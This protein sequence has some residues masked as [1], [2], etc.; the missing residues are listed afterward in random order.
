MQ[1]AYQLISTVNCLIYMEKNTDPPCGRI[2]KVG[3]YK[4]DLHLIIFLF[5][6]CWIYE[7]ASISASIWMS[8]PPSRCLFTSVL[9]SVY[10]SVLRF[11]T[12]LSLCLPITLALSEKYILG[13]RI[14]GQS[15]SKG[16]FK[17]TRRWGF[18]TSD[19]GYEILS[20]FSTCLKSGTHFIEWLELEFTLLSFLHTL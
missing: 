19:T 15:G 2:Y 8:V 3:G 4:P 16:S 12:N 20:K 1:E 5:S 9:S 13:V 7:N 17:E 6:L 18:I 11:T 10:V 14:D